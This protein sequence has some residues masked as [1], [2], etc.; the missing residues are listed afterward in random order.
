MLGSRSPPL[1]RNREPD[2]YRARGNSPPPREPLSNHDVIHPRDRNDRSI[3]DDEPWN[4][5]L[6]D[7]RNTRTITTEPGPAR[8]ASPGLEPRSEGF[9]RIISTSYSDDNSAKRRRVEERTADSSQARRA[10]SPSPRDRLRNSYP[11]SRRND[12]PEIHERAYSTYIS[13][14][15]LQTFIASCH[16]D[17]WYTDS[18]LA[19]IYRLQRRQVGAWAEHN[20]R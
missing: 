11:S 12:D 10:R 13:C 17:G 14:I 18:F 2:A 19:L 15:R 7:R 16:L 4:I 5:T 9:S 20:P 1:H 6:R 8:R 3:R